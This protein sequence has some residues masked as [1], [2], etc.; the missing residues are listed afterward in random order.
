MED[1]QKPK[2]FAI[3]NTIAL[4]AY[5]QPNFHR[6]KHQKLWQV[7]FETGTI[8]IDNVVDPCDL[9]FAVFE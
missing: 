9:S 2:P 8:Q 6:P 7:P 1:L 5:P 4:L 3:G